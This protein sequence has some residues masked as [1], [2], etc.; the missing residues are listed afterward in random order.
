M[1]HNRY[2]ELEKLIDI[3]F[4]DYSI[5]DNAFVHK[6]FIN[7]NSEKFE[8]HNERLEF[9][10]DAVLE[11][12][13]TDFLYNQYPKSSE[14]E[15]TNWRSALV[16]GQN[17]A[18]VALDLKLGTYLYLSKGEEIS[19]GRKKNYIL[20]NTLEAVIGAIYLDQGYRAAHKFIDQ[21]VITKL[22]E[23]IGSKLH[24]DAKSHFQEIAQE[25][26]N[27]TPAYKL[28]SAEG[29]D[30]QK[31]FTMGAYLNDEL[32]ATGAGSSKQKAEQSAA[33]AALKAKGW[34]ELHS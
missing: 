25:K 4:E 6:S 19:G 27:I 15:L 10:G 31:V 12:V 13:V 5:I 24:I 17:L 11:L 30:H 29:P 9:L 33:L 2:S 7:E 22:E 8:D 20:A 34:G 18:R 14:G 1:E 16:K 3:S 26:V 28:Q 21:F 23:I 32:V